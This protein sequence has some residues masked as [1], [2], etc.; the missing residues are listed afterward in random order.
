[1]LLW[2]DVGLDEL[3]VLLA[4]NRIGGNSTKGGYILIELDLPR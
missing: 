1:M 4:A 3:K 2:V